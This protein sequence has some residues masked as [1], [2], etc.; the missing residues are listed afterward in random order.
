MI[1]IAISLVPLIN[2]AGNAIVYDAMIATGFTVRG[3]SLVASKA[4]S[5]LF[6]KWGGALGMGLAGIIGLSFANVLWP[7][8]GALYNLRLYYSI[9]IMSCFLLRDV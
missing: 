6:L 9:A 1:S 8:C 5:E 3:L 2:K 4:P 7:S